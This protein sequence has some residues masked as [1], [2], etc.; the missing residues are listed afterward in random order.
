MIA[1][2][3]KI[4]ILVAKILDLM[5]GVKMWAMRMMPAK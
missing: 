3:V 4:T 2:V 5:Y 1:S